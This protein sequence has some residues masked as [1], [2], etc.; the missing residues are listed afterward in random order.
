MPDPSLDGFGQLKRRRAYPSGAPGPV[1]I[2][3]YGV[4]GTLVVGRENYHGTHGGFERLLGIAN[5]P[6]LISAPADRDPVN[7]QLNPAS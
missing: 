3:A 4:D 2:D 1:H 5:G 7:G 6:K